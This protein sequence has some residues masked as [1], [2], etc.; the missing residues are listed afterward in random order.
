MYT[1]LFENFDKS[2]HEIPFWYTEVLNQTKGYF[3]YEVILLLWI[4]E[5]YNEP[6]SIAGEILC[7]VSNNKSSPQAN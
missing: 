1:F 6:V 3:K 4:P 7:N 2:I 5:E